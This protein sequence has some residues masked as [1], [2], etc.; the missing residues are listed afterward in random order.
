[1]KF[2]PP[3]IGNYMPPKCDLRMIDEHF[4]SESVVV[5]TVS[6]SADK[7]VKTVDI[8]HKGML[9][10]EEP[11]SVM[12]NNFGPPIIEDWHSND[13]SEDKLSPTVEVKTV[14][15]SVEKIE[16]VKTPRETVKTIKS[17]KPHKHYHRGNK[18]NWNNLM[19]HRL[20]SNFKMINKACYV[21]GSFVHLQY[22]CHKKDVIPIRN[23]SNMVNHKK[24]ANKFTHAHPKRG[25]IS[26]AVLTRSTK[27]NIGDASVNTA[28][29]PVNAAGS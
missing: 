21:C 14:K 2:P 28:V 26:Q 20:G 24:I 8:T 23:K 12:K 17:H 19:S 27:I 5:S 13:D 6:S 10:I 25:F 18:R 4:K 29:R 3:L 11:K 22:V 15:P 1:M 9:S 16:S 7:T